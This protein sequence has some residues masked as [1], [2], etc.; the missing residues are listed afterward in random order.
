MFALSAAGCVD[1]RQIA[2]D[3]TDPETQLRASAS[4]QP[5][6]DAMTTVPHDGTGVFVVWEVLGRDPED[7][8]Y[9]QR[10]GSVQLG[11]AVMALDAPPPEMATSLGDPTVGTIVLIADE[12][13]LPDGIVDP[14]AVS[15]WGRNGLI[16]G[17][18]ANNVIVYK[19]GATIADDPF[20]WA[21]AFEN[22][23]GCGEGVMGTPHDSLTPV[24]CDE[25]EF[26]G[27][28]GGFGCGRTVETP[29]N[30]MCGVPSNLDFH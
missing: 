12:L 5:I 14:D 26:I 19:R 20:E 6:A 28:E 7:Y 30:T 29:P 3:P 24:E 8:L 11:R 25:L 4:F 21:G 18:S 10:V 22:G 23:Y 9:A 13:G 27:D 2:D 16:R 15:E 17:F 1:S